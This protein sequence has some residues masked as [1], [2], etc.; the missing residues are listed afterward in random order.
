MTRYLLGL[1]VTLALAILVAPLAADAP[2]PGHVP[3]VGFLDPG[4]PEVG[5]AFRQGL[6]ELGY[7]EEHNVILEWR[8]WQGHP[9]RAP[10]LIAELVQLKVD[11]L[12]VP[13]W[14]L[15]KAARQATTTIPIVMLGGG[16]PVWIGAAQFHFSFGG[17]AECVEA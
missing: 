12:V 11:V 7:V 15:V 4:Q 13:G 6:Q 2:R 9:A 8:S 17:I 3:R 1:L 10:A 16:D 5:R 14:R